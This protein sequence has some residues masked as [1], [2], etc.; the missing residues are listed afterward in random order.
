MPDF[1][2]RIRARAAVAEGVREARSQLQNFGQSLKSLA[3]GQG[4]GGKGSFFEQLTGGG[5]FGAGA[6]AATVL[7][8]SEGIARYMDRAAEAANELRRAFAAGEKSADEIAAELLKAVP[9]FGQGVRIGLDIAKLIDPTGSEAALEDM[10][11]IAKEQKEWA[12]AQLKIITNAQNIGEQLEFEAKLAAADTD[13]ARKRLEIEKKYADL[14][15]NLRAGLGAGPASD[16][17]IRRRVVQSD[18]SL[19]RELEEN[20]KAAEDARTKDELK[21]FQE[22]VKSAEAQAKTIDDLERTNRIARIAAAGDADAT[23][24]AQIRDHYDRMRQEAKNALERRLIDEQQGLAEASLAREVAEREASFTF[25]LPRV[26]ETGSGFQ[27]LLFASKQ[28]AGAG[29]KTQ[30]DILAEQ[31]L[32]SKTLKSIDDRLQKIAGEQTGFTVVGP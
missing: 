28:N 9:F 7:A 10:E 12:D 15:K 6:R 24:L 30:Q 17:E 16:A 21:K 32:Q 22:A 4:I 25:T 1:D 19:L 27:S 26:V 14:R 11:R 5:A 8:A 18:Q 31:K 20:R 2:I 29:V 13:E 23:E 3:F